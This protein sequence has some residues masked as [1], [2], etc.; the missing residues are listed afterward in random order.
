MLAFPLLV[1]GVIS[2]A[3]MAWAGIC[4]L[5]GCSS[6]ENLGIL[7]SCGFEGLSEQGNE[8]PF[9]RGEHQSNK[10]VNTFFFLPATTAMKELKTTI[11]VLSV[12]N[13]SVNCKK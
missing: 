3:G 12:C 5:Q 13:T 7:V 8:F 9:V 4:C 2:A 6:A 10:I 11:V 1:L